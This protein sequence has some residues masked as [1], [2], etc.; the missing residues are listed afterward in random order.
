MMEYNPEFF[1]EDDMTVESEW[2][3]YHK[4]MTA[5]RERCQKRNRS[6]KISGGKRPVVA[7]AFYPCPPPIEDDQDYEVRDY[8]DSEP[9]DSYAQTVVRT[10]FRYTFAFFLHDNIITKCLEFDQRVA[11]NSCAD[12]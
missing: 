10:V 8:D 2:A 5:Q 11:G 3:D 1:G 12:Q 9:G 6:R 4:L 7:Q